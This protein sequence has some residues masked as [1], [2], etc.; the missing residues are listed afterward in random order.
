MILAEVSHPP[1]NFA[2]VETFKHRGEA[3]KWIDFVIKTD[4]AIQSYRNNVIIT[5]TDIPTG[6]CL[7]RSSFLWW[8]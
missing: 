1:T 2:R 6:S 8:R 4:I 5:I 7:V 3:N